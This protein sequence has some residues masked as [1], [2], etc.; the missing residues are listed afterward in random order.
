[1]LKKVVLFAKEATQPHTFTEAGKAIIT[2]ITKNNIRA[3]LSI[4]TKYI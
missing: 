3:L 4:P 1:M 2:V